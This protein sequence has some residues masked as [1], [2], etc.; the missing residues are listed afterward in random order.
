MRGTGGTDP[1]C[2]PMR[3]CPPPLAALLLATAALA[4]CA[5]SRSG[6]L[7]QTVERG[8]FVT[9]LGA[10][11]VAVERFTR[12][13]ELI[14]AVA[15]VRVPTT[16]VTTYSLAI[17]PDGT[18]E[19]YTAMTYSG[20]GAR[21]VGG[22][23]RSPEPMQRRVEGRRDGDTLRVTTTD[24]N[25]TSRAQA[26]AAAGVAAP[27]VEMVHWPFEAALVRARAAG[28]AR[29]EQPLF[30]ERGLVR[31]VVGTGEGTAMTVTH[32]SRGTMQVT[33]DATGRLITLDAGATTRKLTV[34]RVADVD[35]DMLARRFAARDAAGQAFGTLSGR[36]QPTF[37]LG[38]ATISLDYGQPSAR[39]RDL[40][41]ALV[42][43]GE[44]WRT[45][46]DGAT[47][48]ETDRDLLVG[49]LRV[50]AGRYTLSS[51]PQ[52]DGGLLIVNRQTGQSGTSYDASRDLG[53]VPMTRVA[54]DAPVERLTLR[55][56]A[57]GSGGSDGELRIEWGTTAFTVPIRVA[58]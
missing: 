18:V 4:G 6:S 36:A 30:T 40:F 41:G 46:A 44:R 38:G 20:A 3:P 37:A 57:R 25:G 55:V 26:I 52:P 12:S 39:G 29:G 31:F 8:A 33:A 14:E 10:D 28:T 15:V 19:R 53:R 34:T 43:W 9:R 58:P 17:A 56:V 32:P 5:G 54:L 11:T 42:P 51:I 35:L 21:V 22:S 45:G 1:A 27:F 2:R 7:A 16:T 24:Q 13:A 49:D 47:H 48:F 50:P 23:V